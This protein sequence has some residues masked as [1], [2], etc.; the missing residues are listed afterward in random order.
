[1]PV[2]GF[3]DQGVAAG[4]FAVD[5]NCCRF[6]ITPLEGPAANKPLLL[7]GV[8]GISGMGLAK[9]GVTLIWPADGTG[10]AKKI[11]T[12]REKPNEISLKLDPATQRNVIERYVVPPKTRGYKFN[13]EIQYV[14]PAGT[15]TF[16]RRWTGCVMTGVDSESA[17]GGEPHADTFKFQPTARAA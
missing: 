16:S 10:V 15:N 5:W 4:G 1:M 7:M 12:G 13:F 9:E 6:R 14:D 17:E 8:W 11:T 3:A 2:G